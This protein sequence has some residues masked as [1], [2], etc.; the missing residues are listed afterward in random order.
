MADQIIAQQHGGLVAAEV[1]DGRA[2]AA[3]LGLVEHVVVHE[4]R[5]V[6][7]LDD[8]RDSVMC[9]SVSSP[10]ALPASST[11]RRPKHFPAKAADML[12]ERVNATD[13][14]L[15]FAHGSAFTAASGAGDAFG[16]TQKR[17]YHMTFPVD[18]AAGL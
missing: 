14:A 8:G 11:Q 16:E 15:E 9:A 6:H 17:R 7:H 18:Q 1:I 10:Q 5:H 2:L 12:D 13:F 3:K 4:R